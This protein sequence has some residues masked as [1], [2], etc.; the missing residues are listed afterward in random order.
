MVASTLSQRRSSDPKGLLTVPLFAAYLALS[1]FSMRAGIDAV[2]HVLEPIEQTSS[3]AP[4][5][6]DPAF[7]LGGVP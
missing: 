6:T 2:S 5:T 1:A 7:S 3:D 4:A